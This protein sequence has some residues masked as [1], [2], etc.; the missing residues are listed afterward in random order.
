MKLVNLPEAICQLNNLARIQN[1]NITTEILIDSIFYKALNRQTTLD[2]SYSTLTSA[3][4]ILASKIVAVS[5]NIHT[6]DL[7]WNGLEGNGPAVAKVLVLSPTIHT[8]NMSGNSLRKHA[9]EVAEA[10]VVSISI[11]TIDI[12]WNDL[13][14]DGPD[15]AKILARSSTICTVIISDNNL[16][17][18]G[19]DTAKALAASPT[20]HT[21]YMDSNILAEHGPAVAEVFAA[22]FTIRI[23]NISW[24]S[25]EEYG[26]A[27]ARAIVKS[28]TLT[29]VEL[30]DFDDLDPKPKSE[31][32]R[33]FTDHNVLA[34]YHQII[35][36][37]FILEICCDTLPKETIDLIG[38]YA[39]IPFI[40]FTI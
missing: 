16:G 22:S 26:P 13:E 9:I 20:I 30:E 5:S 31:M 14:E 3:A 12:S 37:N 1:I 6:V 2:L 15:V 10:F 36:P 17:K 19:P 29:S 32:A 18:S 34:I 8:V 33:I 24:N 27:V 11:R 40:E 38:E 39:Y 7:S 28:N 35:V 4:L 23:L 25:F 21:V